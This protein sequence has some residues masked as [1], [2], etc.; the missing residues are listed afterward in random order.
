M[1]V[2]VVMIMNVD[3]HTHFWFEAQ[4]NRIGR[5]ERRRLMIFWHACMDVS[6]CGH[7]RHHRGIL[8]SVLLHITGGPAKSRKLPVD[9]LLALSL[10]WSL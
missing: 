9:I 6:I 10:S 1:E 8:G 2:G 7:E 4:T 5:S 3:T